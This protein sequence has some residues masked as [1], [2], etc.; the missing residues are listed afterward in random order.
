MQIALVGL[1]GAGKTT[2]FNAV[3]ET[4]VSVP[5]GGLQNETH[6]QVVK[7]R[8]PRLERCRELFQPKKY[9]PAGLEIWDPPGLPTG[10]TEADR[11]RRTRVLSGLRE[12]D[13][14]VAVVRAF[15]TDLYPYDRAAP[16]PAADFARVSE[17]LLLADF[18]VAEAR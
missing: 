4:P 16:D 8:D 12:A 10:T 9:T 14:F 1:K 7:V 11:E 18:Q 6:V 2:L 5:A 3:A 13:A 17:E 15:A